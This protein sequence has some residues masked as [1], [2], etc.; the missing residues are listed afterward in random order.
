MPKTPPRKWLLKR[1]G[2]VLSEGG[3]L[4]VF[5]MHRRPLS[6]GLLEPKMSSAAPVSRGVLRDGPSVQRG[7]LPGSRGREGEKERER[8]IYIDRY[9]HACRRGP[10]PAPHAG[11]H[12]RPPTKGGSPAARPPVAKAPGFAGSSQKPYGFMECVAT[13]VTWFGDTDGPIPRIHSASATNILHTPIW[14]GIA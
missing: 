1:P 5:R 10:R 7:P 4:V 9:I 3:G 14:S 11:S 8:E 12:R 2:G 6:R 13:D